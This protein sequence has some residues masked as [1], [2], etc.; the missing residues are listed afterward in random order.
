MKICELPGCDLPA[1]NKYCGKP[2]STK[3]R[4]ILGLYD[5]HKAVLKDYLTCKLCGDPI[6]THT[7]SGKKPI[8][9]MNGQEYC[10]KSHGNMEPASLKYNR[11][12]KIKF[13]QL[14]GCDKPIPDRFPSGRKKPPSTMENA[15]CCCL[16]HAKK[17]YYLTNKHWKVV[18]GDHSFP[19]SGY[20]HHME[21]FPKG[22]YMSSERNRF[23][24]EKPCIQ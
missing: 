14:P 7:K 5:S 4:H 9:V 19:G 13:C 11:E 8:S 20:V 10:C 3:H 23:N 17:L 18:Q 16:G 12:A 1:K 24:F 2:H 15:K 6:P 21:A 22:W